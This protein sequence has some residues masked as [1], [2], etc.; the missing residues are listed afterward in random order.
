VVAVNNR[1]FAAHPDQSGL[2]IADLESA[3]TQPWF[4]ANGLRIYEASDQVAGFCWTKRHPA[5]GP[6]PAMGEIY[7]IAVDPDFHGR[8][9]GTGLT[10]AGLS[11]LHKQGLDVGML[12]VEADNE[13]ALRTYHKL[14]FTR[15]RT[16]TAWRMASPSGPGTEHLV[17][18][19]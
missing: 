3:S 9:L 4:E 1:G 13:P 15:H 17:G 12:Y 2:T 19:G 18:D 16:D 6:R 11:W 14:G 8:G 10:A 7:V 5:H